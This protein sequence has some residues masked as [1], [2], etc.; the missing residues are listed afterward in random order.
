M[1]T[2]VQLLGPGDGRVLGAVADDVFDDPIRPDMAEEFLKDPRHHLAVAVANGLV[3]GFASAVRHVHPDKPHELW[4]NEVGVAPTFQ[5]RG[6]A[7]A[8]LGLLFDV[9]RDHECAEAWV[10][11]DRSNTAAKALYASV[12]GVEMDDDIVGF[13]FDLKRAATEPGPRQRR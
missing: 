9:G 13:E 10:L 7:K 4:I 8:L 12:G 3:V 11:T 1:A 2:R 5:N 6:L